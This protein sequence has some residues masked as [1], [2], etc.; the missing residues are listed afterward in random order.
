M[1]TGKI[2]AFL[3]L[4]LLNLLQVLI[5]PEKRS[6]EKLAQ[7]HFK[8]KKGGNKLFSP[9]IMFLYNKKLILIDQKAKIL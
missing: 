6:S 9:F 7:R 8:I 4:L 1:H 5:L 2:T 3:N